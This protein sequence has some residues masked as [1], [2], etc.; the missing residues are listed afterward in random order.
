MRQ[1][2][3]LGSSSFVALLSLGGL[4]GCGSIDTGGK[5]IAIHDA[6]SQMLTGVVTP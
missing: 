2:F 4:A 5:D 6:I 3:F 1:L